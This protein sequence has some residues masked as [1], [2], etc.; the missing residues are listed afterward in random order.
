MLVP[1]PGWAEHRPKQDWWGDFTF[2]CKKMLTESDMAPEAIRA[3]GTSAI[4]PCMLPVD[5]RRRG[6]VQC[7]ALR[8]RCARRQGDR[9]TQRR[10]RR[11]AHPRSLRQCADLAVGRPEDPVAEEEPPG[12]FRQGRQDRHVDHLSGAEADRRM[13]H[14]PLF[15]GQFLAA[16]CDR[17]AGL[18]H[19]ARARHH[20]ARA[21][22][23]AAVDDRHRRPCDQEGGARDRARR[24]HAGD[25]RHHR[26]GR[27][28]R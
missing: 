4:G 11:Q 28:K 2:I 20:R 12:D 7:R 5:A 15:G 3:V 1:Q 16:L 27:R 24:R 17:Q 13:R 19:R 14:R 9:G 8:R 23:E 21:A 26:R 18:E 25:R 6:A 22:A 10:D